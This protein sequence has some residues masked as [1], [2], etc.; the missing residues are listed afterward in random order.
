MWPRDVHRSTTWSAARAGRSRPTS[1]RRASLGFELQV[2]YGRSA[3]SQFRAPRM[4][5]WSTRRWASSRSPTCVVADYAVSAST[6]R[7]STTSSPGEPTWS[8]GI[9]SA[10][11]CCTSRT[12]PGSP[13]SRPS[14]AASTPSA[15][16]LPRSIAKRVGLRTIRQPD[17]RH[18][19]PLVGRGAAR[20]PSPTGYVPGAVPRPTRRVRCVV[21]RR[22]AASGTRP[23]A[24]CCSTR[25]REAG[26]GRPSRWRRRSPMSGRGIR[27]YAEAAARLRVDT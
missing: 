3:C 11:R 27:G 7:T 10:G 24:W 26:S 21:A 5:T 25:S 4:P 13:T 23:P 20:H 16:I 12:G 9:W 1:E 22:S 2:G 6:S 8:P 17:A 19:G 15:T 14:P 18:R